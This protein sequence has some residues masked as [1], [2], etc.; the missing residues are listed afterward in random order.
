MSGQLVAVPARHGG[1]PFIRS[2]HAIST[3]AGWTAAGLLVVSLLIT[4]EMIFSRSVLGNSTIWQTE[5]VIFLV[6]S[7]ICIGL[8]YVQLVRGHVNVDLLPLALPPRPR[9]LW[10]LILLAATIII[11]AMMAWYSLDVT[12]EAYRR[13]WKSP[14]VWAPRIWPVWAG[15]TTGFSLMLLQ[16]LADFYALLRKIDAPFSLEV[17]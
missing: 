16:L 13:N 15:V 9:F 5:T 14:S 3:F 2:V 12:Q 6:I 10:S 1:N 8:P 4:C 17:K 11:I 7:A